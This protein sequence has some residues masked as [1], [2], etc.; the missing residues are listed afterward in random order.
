MIPERYSGEKLPG[1]A[2]EADQDEGDSGCRRMARTVP[3]R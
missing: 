2:A 1:R 3:I